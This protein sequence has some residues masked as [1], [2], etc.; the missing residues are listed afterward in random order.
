MLDNQLARGTR[1]HVW[2]RIWM[3]FCADLDLV[4]GVTSR[5]DD[6][7]EDGLGDDV[8]DGV[9][10]GLLV[11]GD[12]ARALGS[13]PDDGV[14]GPGDGSEGSDLV[15]DAL[16]GGGLGGSRGLEAAEES[17]EDG[18]EH[19]HAEEPEVVLLLALEEGTDETGDD[20][21]EIDAKEPKGLVV[22]GTGEAADVEELEGGGEGPIDVTGVEELA[23]VEFTDVDTVAGGHGEVGEGGNGGDAEG[24][25][26]VLAAAIGLGGE[27]LPEVGGGDGEAKEG[28]PEE[29]VAL[30]GE[31]LRGIGLG[32]ATGGGNHGEGSE[33]EGGAHHGE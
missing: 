31:G 8:E 17:A 13:E 3:S 14:G 10:H 9:G 33:G 25:D 4:A 7:A 23:A 18:H 6:E 1:Q 16:D 29:L 5:D 11:S 12:L 28:N 32:R 2:I 24:D 21:E 15:E 27:L 19:A 30:V 20:H 22:G 26:V